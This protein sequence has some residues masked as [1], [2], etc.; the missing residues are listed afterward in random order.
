MSWRSGADLFAAMW[1]L[2]REK[3]P[4]EEHRRDFT[5][6]LLAIM[7]EDDLDPYNVE[8]I[9]PEVHDILKTLGCWTDET[10]E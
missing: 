8:D 9:D 10:D 7:I 6:R 1:P 2:I 4:D 3:I 5:A